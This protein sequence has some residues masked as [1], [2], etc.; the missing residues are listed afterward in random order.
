MHFEGNQKRIIEMAEK[1]NLTKPVVSGL[2]EKFEHSMH[3]KEQ[4]IQEKQKE[5]SEQKKK[6][7]ENHEQFKEDNHVNDYGKKVDSLFK[8]ITGRNKGKNTNIKEVPGDKE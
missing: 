8:S 3:E 4:Q 6:T 1:E 2:P 7:E 5:F